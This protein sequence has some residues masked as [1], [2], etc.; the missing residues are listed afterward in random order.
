M[1]ISQLK[2][3]IKNCIYEVLSEGNSTTTLDET[4]LREM[5]TAYK[6][7]DKEGFA[8]AFAEFKKSKG[9]KYDK[10]TLGKI[11]KTLAQDGEVDFRKLAAELGKSDLA[12]FNNVPVRAK[13]E[14]EGGEFTDYLEPIRKEK[15]AAAKP[16]EDKEPTT[17]SLLQEM[18]TA[19]KVKDK[20]GFM[21]ALEKYKAGKGEKFSKT[22]LA[23]ILNALAEEG[24]VDYREL[25]KKMGK[26]DLASF[27]NLSTRAKLE[28]E[29][30]EFTDF[31]E[32]LRKE[33]KL[34]ASDIEKP[35]SEEKPAAKMSMSKD[36]D[37]DDLDI[38]DMKDDYYKD[39]E[40]DSFTFDK[41]P[42]AKELAKTNA[43]LKSL[44]DMDDDDD[45]EF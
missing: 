44:E 14:D 16:E 37:D 7:K 29:G 20:E 12:S 17:E 3:E 24:E 4:L 35:A 41:E 11:L 28:D 18:A 22:V 1:K 10:T 23:K 25:G 6:V 32:P 21:D 39:E 42:S 34:T 2:A 30:G 5:A 19:Y 9:D 40:E 27:N 38:D 13:L 26:S 8:D 45:D 31:L 33:K 43:F 36:D 15:K